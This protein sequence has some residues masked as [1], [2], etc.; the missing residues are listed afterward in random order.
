MH[1]RPAAQLALAYAFLV[2]DAAT[3]SRLRVPPIALTLAANNLLDDA[4][5]GLRLTPVFGLTVP[6]SRDPALPVTSFSLALQLERR[7]GP[8]EV[9]LRTEGSKPVYGAP[10]GF[11]FLSR[12]EWGLGNTLQVEGWFLPRLSLGASLAWNLAFSFPASGPDGTP[13]PN[14]RHRTTARVFLTWA[15]ARLFGLT[16]EVNT[17]QSPLHLDGRSVRFPFLSFGAWETN[18]TVLSLNLW[19]R[20]DVTLQRNWLE[21]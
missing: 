14:T 18:A 6:T 7:F 2:P 10:P 15:F 17:T 20:S 21:R 1:L 19:F 8:V 3:G 9:A 16:F 11:M 12:P 13:P 5:T 4:A